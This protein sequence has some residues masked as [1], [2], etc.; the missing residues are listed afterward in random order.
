MA[1]DKVLLMGIAS[2]A[3]GTRTSRAT[4]NDE[5]GLTWREQDAFETRWIRAW[6]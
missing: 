5:V 4:R 6:A 1:G 2:A 3:V